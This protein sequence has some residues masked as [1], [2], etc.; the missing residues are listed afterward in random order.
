[1]LN[2][3]VPSGDVI[4]A[5]ARDIRIDK[6]MGIQHPLYHFTITA[7]AVHRFTENPGEL[8][9]KYLNVILRNFIYGTYYS[10]A[11]VEII[12]NT[13]NLDSQYQ[14]YLLHHNL[15]N[16]SPWGVEI[17]F[18]KKLHSHN[19]GSGY[20]E[21]DW[22]VLRRE[23]DGSLAV[24]KAGLTM[25]A[26]R[27]VHWDSPRTPR[28][29]DYIAIKMPKN[30]LH[31]GYYIAISNIGKIEPSDRNHP[32]LG[33]IYLNCS[34]TGGVVLI[35]AL[36]H[37]LNHAEIYFTLQMLCH[38]QAFTRYDAG[39]LIFNL[40]DYGKIH[41]I[42]SQI[43]SQ[44]YFHPEIPI[45]T[46]YLAPGIGFA[47]EPQQKFYPQEGYGSNRCQIITNALIETW[48]NGQDSELERIECINKHFAQQ[49][50]DLQKPYLNPGSE[51]IYPTLT[52]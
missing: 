2:N 10:A 8:Q 29:G 7:E 46:K 37:K 30:R 14:G 44:D 49:Q 32:Q 9:R 13:H 42:L 34:A 18:Y 39:I 23:P 5:I 17:D 28:P 12:K 11:L 40:K 19:H 27:G 36:T 25:Y 51:D 20:L 4:S 41:Q 33:R 48:E 50:I 38:S 3:V 31:N 24:T 1:M 43:Y 35:D 47:E 45:L 15:E 26:T 21:P 52:N 6:N 22:E 16:D